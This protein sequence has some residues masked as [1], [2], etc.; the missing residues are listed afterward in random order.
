MVVSFM[1][2]IMS[3]RLS[4]L[5]ALI[6]IPPA[7]ALAAGAGSQLSAMML[8][9]IVKLAPTGVMLLFAILYF[10]LMIDVGLFDPIVSQ[11]VR[12][13]QGDPLKVLLGTAL[14]AL[15]VSL[16]GDGS[17]TYMVT[18]SSLLPLYR[19]LGMRVL[20]LACVTMLAS[21]VM[22]LT[23]WGGPTARVASA[24]GLDVGELFMPMVPALA[25]AVVA[26]AAVAYLL[27]LQERTRLR[28]IVVAE[29][30]A[31]TEMEC[32]QTSSAEPS[33]RTPARLIGV[34]AALTGSLLLALVVGV[35]PIPVLF[36]LGFA[37]ALAINYPDRADQQRC[38][39][40]HAPNAT[41]VVAVIFA[42]GVFSGILAESGMAAA[43]SKS[44][45]AA[46]PPRMGP[47]LGVVTALMSMPFTFFI[48]N[49][50]FYFGVVPIIAESAQS[51]GISKLEI[52]RAS[53]VGQPVHLLSPLVPSTYLL[54]GLAGVELGDHQRFTIKWAV[55]VCL[56]LLL[57]SLAFSLFPLT[58][59]H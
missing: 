41:A 42:A 55:L 23:P 50:A 47:H 3:K 43:M 32:E 18:V 56:A 37:V 27:G 45:L 51:F 39:A 1:A 28:A 21:G 31:N 24:L 54:V 17:T 12:W 38:I 57:A 13:V 20:P 2:L 36:I 44:V 49:D 33:V 11:I 16:D 35:L 52:A 48:S 59:P 46:L 5:I 29:A 30:P 15:V 26:V 9:G 19:R 7:F 10:G 40:R 8:G 4:P 25:V 14:L 58:S 22:N 34:N 6:L 53:L